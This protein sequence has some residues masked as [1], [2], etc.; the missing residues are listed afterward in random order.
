MIVVLGLGLTAPLRAEVKV[1]ALFSD[2]LVLQADKP[3]A[4]WGTGAAGEKVTVA[5]GAQQKATVTGEDGRWMLR[6]DPLK[7]SA[8]PQV[9]KINTLTIQDVLVGEVWLGSGQSNM[10]MTVERAQD[11]EGTKA[12][13]AL[14]QLRVFS[15][16]SSH[17]A[18]PNREP[19]G[20]WV[21]CSPETV[22]RFSAT[23]F[24]MGR[25]LHEEL[26]LPV[27]LVV[28]AV[29]GTPIESWIDAATQ[30]AQPGLKGFFDLMQAEDAKFDEAKVKAAYDKQL[31]QWT[32]AV[33]KAKAEK[34]QPPQRPRD[35]IETRK[36]KGDVG[37]L[38]N[39]KIAPLIP[40]TIRGAIWYQGEANSQDPKAPFYA[41][42][43]ALLAKDWRTRWGDEWPFAWVQLP[44][45]NRSGEGW[46][47][48][49]EQMRQ[50]LTTIP[51]SGMAITL[52]VGDPKD[53]HPKNK[54][55]VGRRLALWALGKVYGK[56]VVTSGPLPGR[57]VARGSSAVVSF[58]HAKGLRAEGALEYFEAAG[59]DG[60]FHPARAAIEGETVVVTS[61]AMPHP[62]RVRYAWIDNPR[63][64]LYNGAGLPASPFSV[65]VATP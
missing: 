29:G 14:P 57:V 2:H 25:A 50:C 10:G 52:D 49:R 38:F 54:Q 28:S 64:C 32:E 63:A 26:K 61:D 11:F 20:A 19:K 16:G 36:R 39:G 27:G 1:P 42:Q 58:E 41:E 21:I 5:F 53:I 7:A 40:F 62:A 8:E 15:E 22:G 17:A 31:A 51:N 35:P 18:T 33:K 65:P 47:M 6:L 60:A 43:L 56:D 13:A 9:L 59:P 48:V 24:F 30:R 4:V 34:K 45:F 23:A 55:E 44:N 37:G 46:P 3:V 12:K